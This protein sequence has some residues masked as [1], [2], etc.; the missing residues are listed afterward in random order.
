MI[1]KR[2]KGRAGVG[3]PGLGRENI[4]VERRP[5]SGDQCGA[6]DDY[7]EDDDANDD[8]DD[9]NAYED[10]TN[11]NGDCDGDGDDDCDGYDDTY[12]RSPFATR[13]SSH[14]WTFQ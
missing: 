11:G 1:W 5:T 10:D 3:G 6:D 4:K 8:Y 14:A 12:I 9:D 7:D 2:E 13:A